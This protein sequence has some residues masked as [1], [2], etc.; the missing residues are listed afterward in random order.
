MAFELLLKQIEK[1]NIVYAL[2][3]TRQQASAFNQPL[4]EKLRCHSRSLGVHRY[5]VRIAV[6]G[7]KANCC[8]G[9]VNCCCA[10]DEKMRL[11]TV[12]ALDDSTRQSR[13]LAPRR[14][15]TGCSAKTAH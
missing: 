2:H 1:G 6:A 3:S 10:I 9:Q 11:Y 14:R 12:H 15:A 8:C 5:R 7:R 13:T 4:R